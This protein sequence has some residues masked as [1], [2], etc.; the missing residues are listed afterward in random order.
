MFDSDDFFSV[1]ADYYEEGV[2]LQKLGIEDDL[3]NLKR[4]LRNLQSQE[5]KIMTQVQTQYNLFQKRYTIIFRLLDNLS[6]RLIGDSLD[7][8]DTVAEKQR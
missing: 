5:E 7:G 2:N 6:K 3:I 1:I 4:N 8:K